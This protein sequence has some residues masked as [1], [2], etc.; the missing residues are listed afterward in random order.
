MNLKNY[1]THHQDQKLSPKVTELL[2]HSLGLLAL[3]LF[4]LVKRDLI[5][6]VKAKTT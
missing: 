6:L 1:S 3:N 2:Q 5:K 4:V